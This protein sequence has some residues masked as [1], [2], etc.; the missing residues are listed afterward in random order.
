[1]RTFYTALI[2]VYYNTIKLV[3]LV[4]TK[5]KLFVQGRKAI[6]IQ[7]QTFVPAK[8]N[9]WF[10][11]ASLGEFE[12]ARPLIEQLK[13]TQP[14]IKII[15]TFFSPSGYEVRKNYPLADLVCYMPIDTIA[16]ATEFITR[17]K[18]TKV[19]FI[20]YEF[21]FNFIHVL[22]HQH[23]PTYYV[24]ALLRPSQYFFKW[25]G[26]WF[27]NEL[28]LIT[29]FFTQNEQTAQLLASIGIAQHTLVGD[30]RYDRV[31]H[32]AT[33]AQPIDVITQFAQ[34]KK[35]I[36]LG[37]SWPVD[38]QLWLHLYSTNIQLQTEYKLVIAPHN[39]TQANVQ[40]LLTT[41]VNYTPCAY[42]N[43][44]TSQNNQVL[45]IDNVGMLSSIY[46]MATIAYVGGG[47]GKAVH[48]TLEAAVYGIPVLFGPN[49]TKFYEVQE[50]LASHS[51]LAVANASEL[52][53]AIQQLITDKNKYTQLANN[54][55]GFVHQ[56]LGATQLILKG[57]E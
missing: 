8:D 47:F 51:A 39:V 42:S 30:T 4:N 18:P 15:V 57:I 7:L 45:V 33:Q 26:V 56:R 48:N 50:L 40:A 25:Y 6:G 35:L 24:C 27:A 19:F 13:T 53:L 46:S 1:M 32:I 20:K 21:W 36:V 23:I 44:S 49:H 54:A 28:K 43:F 12:Q 31:Y 9:Y 16:N 29:Y 2:L 34:G 55:K 10:H 17:I 14:S 5:A 11:C 3:A 37:S 22:H 52:A 41:F 38:E